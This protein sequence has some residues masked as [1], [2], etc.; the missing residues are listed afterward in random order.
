MISEIS[1]CT[2]W[3][4]S[5]HF[6]TLY[7]HLYPG[8]NDEHAAV[9]L[10]GLHKRKTG[11]LRLLVREICIAE[12]GVDWVPAKSGRAY[13]QLNG[14][15]VHSKINT[16]VNEQLV[17][18]YVHNHLSENEVDFSE[19]DLRSH[20][21]GYPA[22][23]DILDGLPMGALVFG[24]NAIAGHIWMPGE[25][26]I[27]VSKTVVTGNR[28]ESFTPKPVRQVHNSDE[29]YERQIR[30]FGKDSQQFLS[31][32]KIGIVGLGGVGSVAA[33]LLGRIGI[34]NFLL[35]D[36]ETIEESNISRLIAASHNDLLTEERP[37]ICEKWPWLC[38]KWP[39]LCQKK[40]PKRKIDLA[41]HNII[42]ANSNA[43]ITGIQADVCEKDVAHS[44]LDCDYIFSAADQHSAKLLVNAI[45]HQYL[46]PFSQIGTKVEK[47]NEKVD[48]IF[49]VSKMVTPEIGC[50][51]CGG[52]I[53]S[54]L[55]N[56]ETKSEEQRN[57]ENYGLDTNEPAPSLISLNTVSTAEAI[58]N[59][60][61]YILGMS[62][63]SNVSGYRIFFPLER[64]IIPGIPR[65]SN[66]CPW[67]SCTKDS[68]F[69]RGELGKNLPCK[70]EKRK[71]KQRI[72][73]S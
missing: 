34:G 71:N 64:R 20:N 43:K 6:D 15:F 53:N 2:V 8:D 63:H 24:K 44:L 5:K 11:E 61:F 59:F 39:W 30:I 56:Q 1:T 14:Q 73:S 66:D 54:T 35:I 13:R 68:Q 28:Y 65:S 48:N 23:L 21:K 19:D 46:I 7:N 31:D 32:L 52:N 69:A 50:L 58:N 16:C 17:Y 37:W 25:H 40:E 60:L 29:I 12:D 49:T 10:A 70:I 18:L 38:K 45:S 42:R 47:N 27:K 22:L 26:I 51:W 4:T 41:K 67:C 9:L 62:K 36:P 55:I 3:F 72:T 57:A 33:E